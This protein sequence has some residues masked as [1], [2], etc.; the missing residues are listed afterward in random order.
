MKNLQKNL[1]VFIFVLTFI[2]SGAL[3][4]FAYSYNHNSGSFSSFPKSGALR[5]YF[6]GPANVKITLSHGTSTSILTTQGGRQFFDTGIYVFKNSSLNYLVQDS[7]GQAV[8]WI[9]MSSSKK[10]GSG[11]IGGNNERFAI[12]DVSSIYNWVKSFGEPVAS[13]QCWGD[14]PEWAGDLDFNDYFMFYSYTPVPPTV[15]IKV[16]NSDSQIFLSSPASYALS[17]TSANAD[18]CSAYSSWTGT[19]S[20]N[21]RKSYSS[22]LSGSYTYSI[23][24]SNE[25]GS[26][27]DSV[28][29]SIGQVFL[30]LAKQARD[31]LSLD[32]SFQ[33]NIYT[34]PAKEIEF[35][36]SVSNPSGFEAKNVK[37]KDPMP[38]GLKYISGS[39]SVDGFSVPDSIISSGYNLG[40]LFSGQTKVV[41]FRARLQD[42]S[43]FS[44]SLTQLVNTAS[45]R[46]D[47]ASQVQD[48]AIVYAVK[49][50]QVLGAATVDTGA[51]LTTLAILFTGLSGAL[52]LS[53]FQISRRIYWKKRI[54]EA[55]ASGE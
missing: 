1:L 30:S 37:I 32:W 50:G 28:S 6:S 35:S 49:Q 15:D 27:T 11:L 24:C 47:N 7:D 48:T 22:V 53:G 10:C 26:A 55:R 52:S 46:A 31:P 23:T 36:L 44:Q 39:A 8:G 14:S 45:V 42:N 17:W 13:S 29:V 38:R 34:N 25:V 5:L 20:P 9:P 54:K 19:K 51:D 3:A 40:T 43:Y 18:T 16:N 41:K 2:L 4:A 21:G 12:V 33:E